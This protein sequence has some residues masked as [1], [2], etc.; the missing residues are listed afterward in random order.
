MRKFKV[1]IFGKLPGKISNFYVFESLNL[2]RTQNFD[3]RAKNP[4]IISKK[5]NM[6]LR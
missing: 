6:K 1:V 5:E 4:F 2:L 3:E